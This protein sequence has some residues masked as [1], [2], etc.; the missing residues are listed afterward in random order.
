MSAGAVHNPDGEIVP[1]GLC[2]FVAVSFVIRRLRKN[3]KSMVG[4]NRV[5]HNNIVILLFQKQRIGIEERVR[6][7]A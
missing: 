7:K 1:S 4:Y 6:R 3:E 5:S 2:G